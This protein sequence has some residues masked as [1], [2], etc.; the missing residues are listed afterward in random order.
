MKSML[1]YVKS[2]FSGTLYE[3]HEVSRDTYHSTELGDQFEGG[4]V[5]DGF[6][7]KDL[8]HARETYCLVVR[9]G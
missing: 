3:V 9:R 4:K 6:L 7:D 1:Q 5:V 8:E 2:L